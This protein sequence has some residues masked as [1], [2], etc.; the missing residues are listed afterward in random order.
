[1]PRDLDPG[2]ILGHFQIT[3][4][5]GSGGM[6]VVFQARDLRLGRTVALKVLTRDLLEDETA[7]T[8]FFREGQLA[9]SIVH[10]NVAVVYEIDEAEDAAFIAMELVAGRNLKDV[11][12]EGPLS[13]DRVVSIGR[14]ACDA[15]DAAH[16][17]GVIHRDIKSSNIMITPEGQVKILDFGLAKVRELDWSAAEVDATP[18]ARVKLLH[19]HPTLPGTAVGTPSYMS[20][21]Q[22]SGAVVDAR[23]D[24]FSLGVVLYEA[25]SGQLPFRGTSQGEILDAIRSKDP[26]PLHQVHARV[27][28]DFSRVLSKCLAKNPQ[29]RYSTASE[30]KQDLVSLEKGRRA[31]P[32]RA[33]RWA[34]LLILAV[35]AYALFAPWTPPGPVSVAVLPLRYVGSDP[36]REFMGGLVTDALIAGLQ[37]VPEISTPPY[38]TVDTFRE[39]SL[40]E[41]RLAELGRLLRVDVLAVGS[42]DI[43]DGTVVLRVRLAGA[44]GK[45][46]WET[47]AEGPI[48]RPLQAVESMN[49]KV[50]DHLQ[51]RKGPPPA[52]LASMRTPSEAS[53]EKYLEGKDYYARWDLE[54]DL[55][56]AVSSFREAVELDSNFAA[57]HAGLAR[58]LVTLFYQTGEPSLIAEATE[59][60]DNAR[61]LAPDL[62]E[63]L[64]ARGFLLEVTGDTV[65][66]EK[67]LTR[68]M[69]LAP[70]YDTAYR[71]TASFYADLG[72]HEDARRL[73]ER[74]IALRPGSWRIQYDFGRYFLVFEGDIAEARKHIERAEA[75][76][77]EGDGPKQVLGLIDLKAGKLDDSEK[78][79]REVLRL[80]PRDTTARYNLGWVEYYRGRFELAL[81]NWEDARDRARERAAYHAVVGDALRQLGDD[82][83]A[84]VHYAHA[85]DL[86]RGDLER[87]PD[88]DETRVELATL[89]ATLGE[90]AEAATSIEGALSRSPK[91]F[92][93]SERG[94][95]VNH[96]CGWA[97][98][99]KELALRS[100]A[101]GDVARIRFDPD[102]EELREVPEVQEAL[103][104]VSVPAERR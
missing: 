63:V 6:G 20:P 7:R 30:L 36:S 25:S 72:R 71:V 79:F 32:L 56:H 84:S 46:L 75:L 88:D 62:P 5:I 59:A 47:T 37:S 102:L 48:S 92:E 10:P 65:E 22:A 86:Y 90:C 70:G 99:A 94:T 8:R 66:A 49:E 9:A 14:Q 100:I 21:E 77:P 69:S 33:L 2:R 40:D 80:S 29:N 61:A 51:S 38:E 74:A 68:A 78:R 82:A 11:I 24:L 54:E 67:A 34:S 16:R 60:V 93:F 4:L 26:V 96:R 97:E 44:D 98:E 17:L 91:S 12:Q 53:Y 55:D 101:A 76:H 95:Y 42:V 104:K 31:F 43:R 58:A 73:Y 89:L 19:S 52:A 35:L 103:E 85:L 87:R 41:G 50:V 81:R 23:T 83:S 45:T 1:M 13:L 57:A 39:S 64:L 3:E 15:L 28:S 27:S 18:D